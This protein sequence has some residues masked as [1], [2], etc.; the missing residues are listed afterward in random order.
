MDGARV[1]GRLIE[2]ECVDSIFKLNIQ[3][4]STITTVLVR[5]NPEVEGKPVFTCGPVEP[6]RRIEVSHN[7]KAD[8]RW[9]T[10]GEVETYEL[11]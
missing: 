10:V 8:V 4:S 11:K 5:K 3:A 7:N 9:N 1:V 2:V 6:A